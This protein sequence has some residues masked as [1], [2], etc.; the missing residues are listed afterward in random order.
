MT[1]LLVMIDK[2]TKWIEAK[3]IKKLEGSTAVTFLKEI[4]V[5]YG[6]PIA[7]SPTTAA[8][9]P[10]ASSLAIARKWGSGWL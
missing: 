5:R 10:K 9:S 7:S 6:Y 3:P 4:I 8:T 1:H 2:F